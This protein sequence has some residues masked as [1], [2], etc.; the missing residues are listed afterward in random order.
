MSYLECTLCMY[1]FMSNP[2]ICSLTQD[3]RHSAGAAK[4][5][6]VS[7]GFLGILA[8][9]N[10]IG[11][12]ALL[13]C[14]E[15]VRANLRYMLAAIREQITRLGGERE[16]ER[17]TGQFQASTVAFS[18]ESE[19]VWESICCLSA[20]SDTSCVSL[21]ESL[22]APRCAQAGGLSGWVKLPSVMFH[23]ICH[24]CCFTTFTQVSVKSQ[25]VQPLH[26]IYDM[27][28]KNYIRLTY[29]PEWWMMNGEW[30]SLVQEYTKLRTSGLCTP[31][32]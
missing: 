13:L 10:G 11:S 18:T 1:L 32:P 28:Q 15:G 8:F 2:L 19:G 14:Q 17:D 22:H 16:R 21:S 23:C 27:K 5:N 4:Q 31:S 6:T 30:W 9:D 20:P 3:P 12:Q 25:K 26:I 24:W 29:S 7:R